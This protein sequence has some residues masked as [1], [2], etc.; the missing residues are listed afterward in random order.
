MVT[1]LAPLNH[2]EEKDLDEMIYFRKK[3]ISALKET[4]DLLEANLKKNE[5]LHEYELE[6][7][8]LRKTIVD[9]N[10]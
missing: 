9:L 6:N 2:S 7:E 4:K 10:A 5:Q 1:R 3:L 8:K